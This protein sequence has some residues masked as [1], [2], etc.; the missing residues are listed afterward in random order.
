MSADSASHA[1]EIPPLPETVEERVAYCADLMSELL[2]VRGK[3]GKAIAKAWGLALAT[4]E[5]YA[6]EASRRVTADADEIRREITVRGLGHLRDAKDAKSFAAVGK[7]LADVAGANAPTK[8]E[9]RVTT[10]SL[11]EIDEIK[12]STGFDDQCPPAPPSDPEPKS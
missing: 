9:H 4:V 12:K 11:D 10:V 3:T 8:T 6:A 5:S 2:W 7:L 1:R